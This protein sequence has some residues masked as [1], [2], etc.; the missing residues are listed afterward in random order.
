MQ[1]ELVFGNFE[2]VKNE[3]KY[4]DFIRRLRNDPEGQSGFIEQV[5]ITE[6]QQ[7]KYMDKYSDNYFICLCDGEP[8]GFIGVIDNDIRVSTHPDYQ[9]MGVGVFMV[10][11]I[12][13]IYPKCFAKVKIDNIA[14]FNMFEK[15]GYELKYFIL[16]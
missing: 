5:N 14:S 12:K 11:Q 2:F 13:K 7:A 15:A 10:Q 6:E 16:E 1:I 4:W 8:A 9:L 3:P